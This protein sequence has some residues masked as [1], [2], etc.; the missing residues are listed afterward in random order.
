VW[1]VRIWKIDPS[2]SQNRT[3]I[4]SSRVTLKSNMPVPDNAKEAGDILKKHAK[5][6]HQVMQLQNC[7]VSTP[8]RPQPH[9]ATIAV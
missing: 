3:L 5:L 6:P 9:Q 7:I 1:D 4:A 2:N 8:T